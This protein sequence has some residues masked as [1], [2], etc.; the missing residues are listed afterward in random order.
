[1][2]FFRLFSDFFS[3]FYPEQCA[4]C[5]GKLLRQE[6]VICTQCLIDMPLTG[7]QPHEENPVSQIFWG[8]VNIEGACSYFHFR[9]LSK[10]QHLL[11]QLK[12]NGR[13]DVGVEMG[14]QFGFIIGKSLLEMNVSVIIPVPLHPKRERKRGY[15]QSE[16]IAD[17]ISAATGIPVDIST[18]R[19]IVATKTQTKKSRLERWQNVENIFEIRSEQLLHNKHILLID[20][21]VTTGATLEACAQALLRIEGVK[22][23][24]AT[25]AQA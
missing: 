4:A 14:R 6:K 8:R 13:K 25:L 20:D 3:L 15:N 23:S 22:V 9:K 16:M 10:Y 18:V 24:I 17:G 1:M 11:H 7:Y 21:V 19:R 12:Y 5:R 2:A